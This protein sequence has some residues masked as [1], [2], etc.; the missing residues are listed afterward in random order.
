MS[1]RSKGSTMTQTIE[2]CPACDAVSEVRRASRSVPV[3][4]RQVTIDDEWMRCPCG[5]EF[6]TDEQADRLHRRSVEQ[7]RHDDGL[8]APAEIK[9][10]RDNLGLTQR[11]FELL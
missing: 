8:L 7:L 11:E 2:M 5:E 1:F 10:L 9:A 3:G 6:Y 4:S